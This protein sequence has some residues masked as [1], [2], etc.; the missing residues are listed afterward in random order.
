MN[1]TIQAAWIATVLTVVLGPAASAWAADWVYADAYEDISAGGSVVRP[2]SDSETGQQYASASAGVYWPLA[3]PQTYCSASAQ[4]DLWGSTASGTKTIGNANHNAAYT[5]SAG[6]NYRVNVTGTG[7]WVD[8]TIVLGETEIYV[9]KVSGG[10][11][12]GTA[13]I[14]FSLAVNGIEELWGTF[15]LSADGDYVG[16]GMYS[17][18]FVVVDTG[19]AWLATYEGGDL[20][21]AFPVGSEFELSKGLNSYAT[22]CSIANFDS[23]ITLP[24]GYELQVAHPIPTVSEWGMIVIAVLVLTAGTVVF[25]R[26]RR[27]AAA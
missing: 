20:T 11:K 25:S 10:S 23:E 26:A 27:R 5:A 4:A 15:V 3:A 18:T 9:P 1:K 12:P 6:Y 8:A 2:D 21:T 16:D 22:G 14:E 17:D 24:A 7:A 13:G 19:D